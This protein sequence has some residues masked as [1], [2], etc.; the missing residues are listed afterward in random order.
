MRRPNASSHPLG[1]ACPIP[2]RLSR[3]YVLRIVLRDLFDLL[4]VRRLDVRLVDGEVHVEALGRSY[5]VAEHPLGLSVY[6]RV[7][8]TV[9]IVCESTDAALTALGLPLAPPPPLHFAYKPP[10]MGLVCCASGRP[11]LV[12][13]LP[14]YRATDARQT[15]YCCLCKRAHRLTLATPMIF[16]ERPVA[17]S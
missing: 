11:R 2:P 16:C 5:A 7:P 12:A 9:A 14:A 8:Q 1:A 15:A 6:R 17:L 10:L 3:A 4:F 13:T